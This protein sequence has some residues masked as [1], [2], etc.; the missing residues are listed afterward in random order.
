MQVQLRDGTDFDAAYREFAPRA[1][2]AAT[3]VLRDPLAAEDVVQDVFIE[4]WRKPAA[5]DPARGSLGSYVTMLA[6]SRALDRLRSQTASSNAQERAL[7]VVPPVEPESA[8]DPVLRRERSSMLLDVIDELPRGQQEALI[9]YGIGLS[10]R[11]VAE[12][13]QVPLG[14]AKSRMR[15]GFNKA[16]S[17]LAAA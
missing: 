13:A 8:A 15:L 17:R 4:M 11:E 10:T 1:H 3:R 14:T 9:L 12:A 5:F 16:R 7:R 6:H 2:A